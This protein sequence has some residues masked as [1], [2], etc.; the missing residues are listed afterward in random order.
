[1]FIIINQ[2]LL[3]HHHQYKIT[4][5]SS[6]SKYLRA[7]NKSKNT[8]E[9]SSSKYLRADLFD[10]PLVLPPSVEESATYLLYA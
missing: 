8:E 10:F 9:S 5:H 7:D 1:V 3:V 4:G 6:S 2:K